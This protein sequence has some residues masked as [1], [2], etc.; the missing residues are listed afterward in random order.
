MSEKEYIVTLK[1]GVDYTAFNAEM[2]ATTGGGDIPGRSVTVANARPAS[3]RNTH[4]MLTDEEAA[5]LNNDSRV[6]AVELRPDLRDDIEI[7]RLAVQSGDFSKTD[8][9]R[10]EYVNWGLRRVN[11]TNNPFIGYAVD[12]DYNYTLDGTGV[13]IVI[14]D[15]GIQANHPE[16]TDANNV[17][18]VQQIDWYAESGVSGSMPN[19]HYT[20]YDGHGTHCAG[21]A[22]GKTYGWA[23]NARI[24]A[25]KVDGL[26][27]SSD[28]GVGIPISDVFDIIKEW[29]NNKPVDPTT[30][31]KRPTVVN[32]SWGYGTYFSSITGGEYRGVAWTGT[33]RDTA[34]GMI[35]IFNGIGYRHVVRVASVD[36]DVEELIDAGVHVCIAAGNSKQKID[37]DGGIDY[38]N[39]YTKTGIGNVYYH[40]GGSPFSEEAFV[41]GNIDTDL[42]AN[43]R[44]QK[45]GSSE[46]GPGVNAWAPGT[47][48]FSTLSN[49]TVYT[50]GPYPGNELFKIGSL[51]GTSMAAPQVAGVLALWLQINP[52]ATPAQALSYFT[53]SAKTDRLYT[54]GL[55]N[56]YTDDR[57]LLGSANKFLWNK[58][59]SKTQ[60]SIGTTL[61]EAQSDTA[62]IK[63]YA[64]SSSAGSINEGQTVTITLTTTNVPDG[65]TVDYAITGVETADFGGS[66]S[67]SFTINGNSGTRSFTF[68][69]DLATEGTQTMT[70]SLVGIDRSISVVVNDTST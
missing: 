19:N 46:T 32:M 67:G 37:I 54:T 16:F 44:E 43:G 31:V 48:I 68:V 45:R 33:S 14:Q 24:Y 5:T 8:D 34:K 35:G 21:I 57:S 58:F 27:G 40:R 42:A 51:G 52:A 11:E 6:V 59:N 4:Y 22:T 66:L 10:G 61:T 47:K 41:V 13:D 36:A 15:S 69:E 55:D 26:Q 18:R 3:Q 39:Y 53:G 12:G 20:D 30:G 70:L 50:S 49:V 60:L 1:K 23:K 65:S 62:V 28:P 17:S 25:V 63:T 56:D 9:T 29:H 2:V 64:L 7:G 38:D